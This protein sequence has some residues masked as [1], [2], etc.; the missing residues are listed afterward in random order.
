M[1]PIG[2]KTADPIEYVKDHGNHERAQTVLL[3]KEA[4]VI[5]E[6]CGFCQYRDAALEH[7]HQADSVFCIG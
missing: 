5:L 3:L 6:I 1:L 4:N 2:D 7:R